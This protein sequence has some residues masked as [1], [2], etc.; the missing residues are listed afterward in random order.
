MISIKTLLSDVVSEVSTVKR[1][2]YVN[3]PPELLERKREI[4]RRKL[5]EA[6]F[7]PREEI[8]PA[9]DT[10]L[11]Y[12]AEA[13]LH[14]HY[15]NYLKNEIR[16][17]RSKEVPPFRPPKCGIILSGNCGTGKTMLAN[18][19]ARSEKSRSGNDFSNGFVY[20][21]AHEIIEG[22][23]GTGQDH[24]DQMKESWEWQPVFVDD[25]GL[26]SDGMHYGVKWGMKEF[27]FWRYE[28]WKG[29]YAATTLLTTNFRG[30]DDLVVHYGG[31]VRLKSRLTEM[32][33][34]VPCFARDW[35]ME[36]PA[37]R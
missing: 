21:T 33:V 5:A 13:S 37:G 12:A 27:L 34:M 30:I 24:V 9:I 3:P 11:H 31:D 17:W 19:I 16:Y 25:V 28:C 10:V 1:D 20:R 14:R 15:A 26:E 23:N 4:F 36:H 6:G 18:N 35:R 2:P 29:R 7:V 32:C 22:F 8:R